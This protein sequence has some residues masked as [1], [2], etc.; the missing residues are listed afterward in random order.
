MEEYKQIA[1]DSRKKVLKLVHLAGTSHIGSLM[2]A[3]D[4][5]AVLFE[6][7]K[8]EKDKFILSAGWKACL[9]YYHLWRKGKITQE[10]LDS[11]CL[12]DS[13]F[14]GLAEPMGRMV[15]CNCHAEERIQVDNRTEIETKPTI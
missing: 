2:G 9:L 10:E 7:L 11:Y 8:L 5:F 15:K 3:A 4:I 14:I 13:K 1:L 6:K 12:D